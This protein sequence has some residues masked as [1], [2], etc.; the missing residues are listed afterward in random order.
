MVDTF[1]TSSELKV[2]RSEIAQD[3]F[4]KYKI[5]YRTSDNKHLIIEAGIHGYDFWPATGTWCYRDNGT[6][7][8]PKRAS[9]SG[10]GIISLLKEVRPLLARPNWM[11]YLK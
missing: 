9:I 5:P 8:G 10:I 1:L 6:T 7:V 2:R 11:R 4:K 3:T